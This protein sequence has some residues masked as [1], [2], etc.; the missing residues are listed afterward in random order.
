MNKA[1]VVVGAAGFAECVPSLVLGNLG[2][3][4]RHDGR[5]D[6]DDQPHDQGA[7]GRGVGQR[8]GGMPARPGAE[9]G[10]A[11]RPARLHRGAGQEAV[12]V[13]R[14]LTRRGVPVGRLFLQ[15][16]S[17]DLVERTGMPSTSFEGSIGVS[18]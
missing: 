1:A 16:L 13:V 9:L 4:D 18:L 11:A 5:P 17:D 7:Q 2:V 14:Q 12:Q 6:R 3:P 15:A 10:R 8:L